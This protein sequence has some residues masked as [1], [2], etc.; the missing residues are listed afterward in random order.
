FTGPPASNTGASV[1]TPEQ[2]SD[3][4]LQAVVTR[5]VTNYLVGNK[6]N[7][8]ADLSPTALVSLPTSHMSVQSTQ[9]ATWISPGHSVA[10][11]VTAVDS[12]G[13]SWTLSYD[14]GVEKLDRWYVRSIQ[15]NPTFRGGSP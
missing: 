1:P 3:P 15:V 14:V 6:T 8:L 12:H 9:Q 7:L 11:Q 13:N 5:A 4:S 2:V 10:I